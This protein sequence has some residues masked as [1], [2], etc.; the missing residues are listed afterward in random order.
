MLV[1][2]LP[3]I[4]AA[5]R[6]LSHCSPASPTR[7]LP[8]A[9]TPWLSFYLCPS[10]FI[11]SIGNLK[12]SHPDD[13]PLRLARLN[14]GSFLFFPACRLRSALA[15]YPVACPLPHLTF[16]LAL[17]HF[18]LPSP[19]SQARTPSCAA[20]RRAGD[21]LG[22]RTNTKAGTKHGKSRDPGALG[23][24]GTSACSRA[25]WPS[26]TRCDLTPACEGIEQH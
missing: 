10:Q 16:P 23:A 4:G 19:S 21:P 22:Q 11:R 24:V 20:G 8:S 12:P 3:P 13:H 9:Q 2:S 6:R 17:P 14:L 7:G 18:A 15:F 1:R 26:R 5:P 25:C